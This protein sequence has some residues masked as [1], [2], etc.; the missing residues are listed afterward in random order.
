MYILNFGLIYVYTNIKLATSSLK[1]IL[2]IKLKIILL[3][4]IDSHYL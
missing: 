3:I 4:I 1:Q 2:E